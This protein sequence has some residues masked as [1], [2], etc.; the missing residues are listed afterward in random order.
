MKKLTLIF[1]LIGFIGS[2]QIKKLNCNTTQ[3]KVN[4]VYI[5]TDVCDSVLYQP[6]WTGLQ[7]D[8]FDSNAF[9][10]AVDTV[11]NCDGS[12]YWAVMIQY[13]ANVRGK[14]IPLRL[15]A[16]ILAC[17]IPFNQTQKDEING[18]L[19]KNYFAIQL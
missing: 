2:A 4:G 3:T 15:K 19:T 1:I 16:L 12:V 9:A 18:I 10:F 14:S 5:N 6:D 11:S 13:L 7:N 8:L 17:Q